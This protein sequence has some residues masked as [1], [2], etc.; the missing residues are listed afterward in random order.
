MST[1]GTLR[2]VAL[3]LRS[4]GAPRAAA[5]A[6]ALAAHGPDVVVLGE[7][8]PTGHAQAVLD[9]LRGV[10]LEHRLTADGDTPRSPSAVAIASRAPL[11]GFRL[12][13]AFLSP[14]LAPRL[15]GA[16]YDHTTREGGASDHSA[17]VVDLRAAA[18]AQERLVSSR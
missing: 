4:G 1:D 9:A 12:D 2:I 17:L 16:R 7:A 3:N 11:N 6:A 18:E 10:G 15:L 14:S 5:L 13:H 8:Y